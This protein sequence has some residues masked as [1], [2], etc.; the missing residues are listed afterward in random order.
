MERV[1]ELVSSVK[2]RIQLQL[3]EVQSVR[4]RTTSHTSGVGL[5]GSLISLCKIP[6]LLS[7]VAMLKGGRP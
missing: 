1:E 7:S 6:H 3:L 5:R 4:K 2:F